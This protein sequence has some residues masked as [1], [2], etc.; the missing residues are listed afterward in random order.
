MPDLSPL[1]PPP[2]AILPQ[3]VDP[4]VTRWRGEAVSG[5]CCVPGLQKRRGGGAAGLRNNS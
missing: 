3:I 2:P 5:V 4:A 1:L